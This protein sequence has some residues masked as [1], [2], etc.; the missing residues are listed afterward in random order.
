MEFVS[1]LVAQNRFIST[2]SFHMYYS[3]W[4]W[5]IGAKYQLRLALRYSLA[6]VSNFAIENHVVHTRIV[7][8]SHPIRRTYTYRYPVGIYYTDPWYTGFSMFRFTPFSIDCRRC[9]I[10]F[11]MSTSS[12]KLH[13][14]SPPS[15]R[16]FP[17]PSS[18]IANI[19]HQHCAKGKG[20]GF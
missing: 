12:R 11:T 10:N 13:L 18:N 5:Y 8:C 20:N 7:Y 1:K 17:S 14:F 19:R 4:H 3:V 6:L 9:G 2:V 16:S 15:R